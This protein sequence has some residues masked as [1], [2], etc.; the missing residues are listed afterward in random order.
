METPLVAV[1]PGDGIGPEV[2]AETLK[3]LDATGADIKTVHYDLGAERYLRDGTIL[4][5]ELLDEL[6]TSNAIL[7][8]AIG[9]P[10]VPSGLLEQGLLLKLR[11]ELNLGVNHRPFRGKS[12][13][14]DDGLVVVRENSEGL[15]SGEGGFLNRGSAHEIAMQGS[16]NTR[17]GVERCIRYAFHLAAKRP[18]RHLTMVHKTNVLPYA[19]DLWLRTFH[20][21]SIEFPEVTTE[22][23]HAD[24]ACMYLVQ[25]P[26]QYDVI[27]T[28]NIFGDLLSDVAAAVTGGIGF[29]ASANLNLDDDGPSLFEPVH[30]SAPDICGTSR[31]NPLAAI[32][33]LMLLLE[34]LGFSRESAW[35][36]EASTAAAAMQGTTTAIGDAIAQMVSDLRNAHVHA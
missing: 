11:F 34:T 1:I 14:F 20:D 3:V 15:Y 6:R 36:E 8:G 5:D 13:T 26:T 7:L 9:H 25:D 28:D 19:G 17:R 30:G 21:L 10:S 18:R 22:Y 4:P 33:S 16:I 24:A 23:H 2:I 12:G 32:S 31:A 35:I 27:V 29:A